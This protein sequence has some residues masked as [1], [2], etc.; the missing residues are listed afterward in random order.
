MTTTTEQAEKALRRMSDELGLVYESQDWGIINADRHRLQEFIQYFD[1]QQRLVSTQRF[2]LGEL[3]LASANE[4]LVAGE[5]ALPGDFLEF[6]GRAREHFDVHV[7]YWAGLDDDEEF[8][9]GHWL[10]KNDLGQGW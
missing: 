5:E 10:R 3:I 4:V 6:L 7:E 9:L 8:P 1:A 2:E